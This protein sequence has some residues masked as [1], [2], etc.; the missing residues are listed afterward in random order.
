MTEQ[1]PQ[2]VG[3]SSFPGRYTTKLSYFM[4]FLPASNLA[5]KSR[6]PFE[7]A[8]AP[9]PLAAPDPS[10]GGCGCSGLSTP[11]KRC[12]R[13]PNR[14]EQRKGNKLGNLEQ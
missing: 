2:S 11:D 6:L 5:V 8:Q 3:L 9:P 10:P 12:C 7:V 14:P 1:T 4:V 13:P